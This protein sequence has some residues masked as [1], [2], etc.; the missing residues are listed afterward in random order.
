[1]REIVQITP[2]RTMEGDVNFTLLHL[3]LDMNRAELNLQQMIARYLDRRRRQRKARSIWVRQWITLRPEQGA[4][5][6]LMH[7]LGVQDDVAFK[8]YL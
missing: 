7:L 5:S 6:N 8:N 2:P 1:M 3:A 4:Y